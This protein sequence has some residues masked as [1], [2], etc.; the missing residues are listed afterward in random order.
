MEKVKAAVETKRTWMNKHMQSQSQKPTCV[1]P[2]VRC[3]Q[4]RAE[5]QVC[6]ALYTPGNAYL[7]KVILTCTCSTINP[8]CANLLSH[9]YTLKYRINYNEADAVMHFIALGTI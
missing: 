9:C 7:T 5:K 6:K 4:I 3:S 8:L 1:D 2:V